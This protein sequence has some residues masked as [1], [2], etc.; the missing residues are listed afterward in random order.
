MSQRHECSDGPQADSGTAARLAQTERPPRGGVIVISVI[1]IV[2][3]LG[4]SIKTMRKNKDGDLDLGHSLKRIFNF[5]QSFG[6]C[7]QAMRDRPFL[8]GSQNF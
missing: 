4:G 8:V 6:T 7:Q 3:I 2:S 1:G 5:L